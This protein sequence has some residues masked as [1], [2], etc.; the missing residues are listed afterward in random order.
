MISYA[1]G[2]DAVDRVLIHVLKLF[3]LLVRVREHLN[4]FV[5]TITDKC[6]VEARPMNYDRTK[7]GR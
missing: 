6:K 2:Y 1:V 3:V 7:T 4:S 5:P